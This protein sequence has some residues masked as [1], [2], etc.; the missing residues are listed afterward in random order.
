M[1]YLWLALAISSE[2]VATLSLKASAGFTRLVPSVIVVLGYGAAFFLLS[3][4][5][6]TIGVGTAYAIWAGL[7][8]AGVAVLAWLIYGERLSPM[9][10]AGMALIIVGVVV[11]NLGSRAHA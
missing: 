7:G 2:L 3:L 10:M 9:A 8:T 4:T 1:G 6:R 11:L 5:L